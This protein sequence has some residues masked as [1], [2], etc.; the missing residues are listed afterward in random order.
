M[1]AKVKRRRNVRMDMKG[2]LA[3]ERNK[4]RLF[5]RTAMNAPNGRAHLKSLWD[6]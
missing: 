4:K 1:I 6:I 3:K 2:F 5:N